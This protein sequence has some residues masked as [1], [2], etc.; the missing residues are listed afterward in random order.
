MTS[1]RSRKFG[2]RDVKFRSNLT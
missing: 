2:K 1:A